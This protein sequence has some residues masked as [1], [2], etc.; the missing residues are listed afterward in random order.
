LR[1]IIATITTFIWHGAFDNSLSR[2]P[3]MNVSK[4]TSVP[5]LNALLISSYLHPGLDSH[6]WSCTHDSS[7]CI[8]SLVVFRPQWSTN[9]NGV[10]YQ[11]HAL[12]YCCTYTKGFDYP[13]YF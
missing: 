2:R 11:F 9:Y 1:L 6:W 5:A 13:N 10:L 3:I 4:T 7:T 8:E 12:A